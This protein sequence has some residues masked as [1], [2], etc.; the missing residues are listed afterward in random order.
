MSGILINPNTVRCGVE[1]HSTVK[2]YSFLV[3]ALSNSIG[4]QLSPHVGRCIIRQRCGFLHH[5]ELGRP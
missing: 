2:F 4:L 3:F 1:N 5:A